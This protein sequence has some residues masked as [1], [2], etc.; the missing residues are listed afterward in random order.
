MDIKTPLTDREAGR[1]MTVLEQMRGKHI[2]LREL[3]GFSPE[4]IAKTQKLNAAEIARMA[5]R[6]ENS[7]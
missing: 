6:K 1:V 7:D 4:E 3:R 5:G 2:K